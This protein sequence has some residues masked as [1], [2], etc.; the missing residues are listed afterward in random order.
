MTV[1]KDVER[2]KQRADYNRLQI[3]TAGSCG[4][5]NLQVLFKGPLY[6]QMVSWINSFR[7]SESS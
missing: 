4:I 6:L 5:P 3:S 2:Q 7:L 1:S